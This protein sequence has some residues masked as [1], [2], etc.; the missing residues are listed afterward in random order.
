MGDI[1]YH[2]RRVRRPALHEPMR[3]ENQRSPHSRSKKAM[4][5]AG[6]MLISGAVCGDPA[7]KTGVPLQEASDVAE[8]R[9]AVRGHLGGEALRAVWHNGREELTHGTEV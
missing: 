5:V 8:E 3:I 9:G 6:A 2:A 4:K 1:L 7:R